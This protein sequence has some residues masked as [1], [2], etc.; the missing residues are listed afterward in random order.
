MIPL[1][2][3]EFVSGRQPKFRTL[4]ADYACQTDSSLMRRALLRHAEQDGSRVVVARP[5]GPPTHDTGQGLHADLHWY[6]WWRRPNCWRDDMKDVWDWTVTS[7]VCN[8]ES[9]IYNSRSRIVHTTRVESTESTTSGLEHAATL[10]TLPTLSDRLTSIPLL[11][12]FLAGEGWTIGYRDTRV[13]CGREGLLVKARWEGAGRAPVV[14]AFV[15]EYDVLVDRERGVVLSLVGLVDSRPA[16]VI[17]A[18]SLEFDCDV[19]D[20]VFTNAPPDGVVT[21]WGCRAS[22]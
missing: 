11:P 15:D 18:E 1:E 22:S 14:F 8:G 13:H 7:I 21:V 3:R 19:P 10:Q 17:S 12:D 6:V 16:V 5:A 9:T 20:A 4:V 2:I